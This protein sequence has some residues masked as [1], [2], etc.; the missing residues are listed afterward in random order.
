[1]A[2]DFQKRPSHQR[3]GD[4]EAL[5]AESEADST[6]AASKDGLNASPEGVSRV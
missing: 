4:V 6:G 3:W 5:Q 2:R 1:M